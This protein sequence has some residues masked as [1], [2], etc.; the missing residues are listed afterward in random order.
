MPLNNASAA[1]LSAYQVN[2]TKKI[3]SVGSF[4]AS[5]RGKKYYGSDCPA[6]MNLKE[7]NKIYFKTAAEAES[8]GYLPSS[9]C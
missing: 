8:A 3:N 1:A 6:G 9:S 4:V 5:S 2:N 7:E